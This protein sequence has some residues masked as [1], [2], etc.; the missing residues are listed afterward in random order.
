MFL[1]NGSDEAIDLLIRASCESGKDRI[2]S[3]TPSYGMYQVCADIQG[4]EVDRVLLNE[5]FSLPNER[6]IEA[7]RAEHKLIFLCSPNNPTGNL[8][9]R[10]AVEKVLN[11]F[12][13]IVVVDEAYIDFSES[14]GFIDLLGKYS[15]LVLLRTFSKAWGLAGARCGMAIANERV[16]KSLANIK[17]PYNLNALTQ[18]V[19]LKALSNQEEKNAQLSQI[20]KQRLELLNAMTKISG[21]LKVFKSE[22]N[23]VLI[24]VEDPNKIYTELLRLGIVVRNRDG[25]DLC[26]GCLRLTVGTELENNRLIETLKKLLS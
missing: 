9:E 14:Y 16:V 17:Y 19:V 25:Q 1:G 7:I 24:K 23:F 10:D 12:S 6:I 22:A 26:K 15:N 13:G 20:K 5:D 18:L 8:L 11:A 4:V 2:I 3:I 21:V